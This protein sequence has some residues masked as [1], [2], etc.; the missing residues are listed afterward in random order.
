MTL[1]AWYVEREEEARR[2]RRGSADWRFIEGL[3]PRLK[4]AVLIFIELGDLRLAHRVAGTTLEELIDT[5]REAGVW[6][7]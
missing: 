4:A 3:P 7:P 6:A 5:L 1:P 2:V